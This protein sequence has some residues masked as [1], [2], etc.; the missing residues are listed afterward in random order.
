MDPHLDVAPINHTRPPHSFLLQLLPATAA[1]VAVDSGFGKQWR[2]RPPRLSR[3]QRSRLWASPPPPPAPDPTA[4]S[5]PPPSAPILSW[6][7][8]RRI[9][10]F[11]FVRL[12]VLHFLSCARA[13]SLG[14]LL[15]RMVLV[16]GIVLIWVLLVLGVDFVILISSFC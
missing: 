16:V 4:S 5:W 9:Y 14:L 6:F 11:F 8:L 1:A 13:V 2:S 7:S 3:R 12:W 15:R 10:S